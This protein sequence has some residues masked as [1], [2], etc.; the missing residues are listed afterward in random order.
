MPARQ[1]LDRTNARHARRSRYAKRAIQTAGPSDQS[2]GEVLPAALRRSC[3]QVLAGRRHRG[4][5]QRGLHQ[6]NRRSPV[7]GVAGVGVAQEM[8]RDVGQ[9]AG[10][11]RRLA[12]DIYTRCRSGV[13]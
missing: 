5:A 6:V 2:D 7:Q 4:V 10:V 13:Y 1:A 11:P 9:D 8:G 3:V 12:H